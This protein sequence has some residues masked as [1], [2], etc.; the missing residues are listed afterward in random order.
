M[1]RSYADTRLGQLHFATAGTGAPLVLLPQGGRSWPMFAELAR[2]LAGE[3]RTLAIDLPGS[4]ASDPL[5]PG[6]TFEDIAGAIVDL[7]D[8]LGLPRA[9][10]YGV[11][12]GNKI[13]AALAGGWPDR[14]AKVVLAG[15]SHSIVPG[16][17]RRAQT[18]GKTRRKLLEG[19]DARETALVQ[20]A[21][22][23][24]VI[25]S[26]WWREALVRDPADRALRARAMLKAGDEIAA[27][28]GMLDLYRANFA[29]DLE[30]AYRRIRVPTLVL[31]IA[32]PGEDRLI[33]RQGPAVVALIPG[34]T[35]ET[36]ENEDFHGITLEYRSADLAR[37][38]RR[39][40]GTAAP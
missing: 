3:Y 9:F 21:D 40:L 16:N 32:T 8:G 39:F 12:T 19:A 27:A 28:D 4:G 30:G 17:D 6:T 18:V 37:I 10:V 5:P 13:A 14:V 22:I 15:Q 35:L 24:N 38:L 7:L 33:G 34:A 11:H 31:E 25:S 26:E 20:W 36:I 2:E 23:Y 1:R 29:F